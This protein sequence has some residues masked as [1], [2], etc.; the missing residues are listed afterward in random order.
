MEDKE[1]G[2]RDLI[3]GELSYELVG[4]LFDVHNEVG[5]GLRE[6][7]YQQAFGRW[8]GRKGIPFTGKPRT[9]QPVVYKG[10]EVDILEP[11]FDI[12]GKLILELKAKRGGTAPADEAQTLNYVKHWDYHLGIL[13][14]MGQSE[15]QPKRLPYSLAP[16][17]VH[18]DYTAIKPT[19]TDSLRPVAEACR[20][21][22]LAI[23]AQV[24]VGYTANMYREML[25]VELA[26]RGLPFD[27]E[28]VV[29]PQFHGEATADSPIT[30]VLVEGQVVIEVAAI[31]NQISAADRR[32]V[33]TYLKLTAAKLGL[34]GCFSRTALLIRGVRPPSGSL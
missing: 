4:G 25:L 28:V 1:T 23:H 21:S 24:G 2:Q 8:L 14:N 19:M 20:Q 22:L 29:A 32:V 31:C 27:A 9:R 15:V 12:S 33:Q 5:P 6:E 17:Q 34:I 7:C 26:E 30:S 16:A 13:V 18:E 10:R 11:D 3:H